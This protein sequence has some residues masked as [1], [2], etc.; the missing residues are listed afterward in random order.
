MGIQDEILG[1]QRPSLSASTG[2]GKKEPLRLPAAARVC[3]KEGLTAGVFLVQLLSEG[4]DPREGKRKTTEEC[5]E[6][7]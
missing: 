2:L 7:E 1:G 6:G 4:E 3:R 5:R